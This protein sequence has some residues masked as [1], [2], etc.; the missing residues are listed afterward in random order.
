MVWQLIV[1]LSKNALT[2]ATL[3][4]PALEHSERALPFQGLVSQGRVGTI[5]REEQETQRE[6]EKEEK[7]FLSYKYTL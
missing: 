3:V 1:N 6:K 5:L 2:A 4:P 7:A